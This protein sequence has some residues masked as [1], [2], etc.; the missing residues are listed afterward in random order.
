MLCGLGFEENWY[1]HGVA[2]TRH[3][4]LECVGNVYGISISST[5]MGFQGPGLAALRIKRANFSVV[6]I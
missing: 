4:S 5:G 6:N 1:Q 2:I 3:Y